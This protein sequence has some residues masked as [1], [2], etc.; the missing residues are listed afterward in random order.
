MVKEKKSYIERNVIPLLYPTTSDYSPVGVLEGKIFHYS[1]EKFKAHPFKYMCIEPHHVYILSND[2]IEKDDY[3]YNGENIFKVNKVGKG[4]IYTEDKKPIRNVSTY[5]IIASSD[6]SIGLPL[7][8]K[9]FINEIVNDFHGMCNVLSNLKLDKN[10]KLVYDLTENFELKISR[11]DKTKEIDSIDSE[12]LMVGNFV[13]YQRGVFT[14]LYGED[15][16]FAHEYLPIKITDY[17]LRKLNFN[18]INEDCYKESYKNFLIKKSNKDF[19]F[20]LINN[21]NLI[22]IRKIKYVHEIQNLYKSLTG[23]NIEHIKDING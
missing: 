14:I 22:F 11:I 4:F 21:D 6:K 9:S 3:V 16:D 10:N 2:K 12:D 23:V 15:I 18:K 7:V 20:Y 8:G 1:L 5:K 19:E 13:Y 17:W